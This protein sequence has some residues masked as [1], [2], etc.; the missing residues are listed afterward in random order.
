MTRSLC[1]ALGLLA[2]ILSC[3]VFAETLSPVNKPSPKV[4]VV[5]DYDARLATVACKRWEVTAADKD[6]STILE[7]GDN[8]A[9]VS[10][11]NGNMTKIVSKSGETL[12]EFKPQSFG[13]S[14]P[15]EVGKKWDGKY[16][17]YLASSDTSWD[18][19]AS[20]EVKPPEIVTVPAGQF[21]AYRI[22]CVHNWTSGGLD[23]Q[24][25]ISAWYAPKVG[26]VVKSVNA[27]SPEWNSQVTSITEK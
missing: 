12:V 10:A 4:G 3:P 23:G 17:G 5:I 7:C 18:G 25:H 13:L 11:A 15:L 27:E 20:C 21:D 22:D 26:A 24:A 14:F 8:I 2:A 16:T 6:G 19:D 1:G 9:Y